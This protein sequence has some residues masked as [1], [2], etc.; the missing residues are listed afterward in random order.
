[1]SPSSCG[2]S[3]RAALAVFNVPASP[4]DAHVA[5]GSLKTLAPMFLVRVYRR[6]RRA[7]DDRRRFPNMEVNGVPPSEL[8]PLLTRSGA[9]VVC[10]R[11]DQT[12]G[13]AGPGFLYCITAKAKG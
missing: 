9:T 7:L 3:T 10:V 11:P 1:M 8:V 5:G 6:A 12:H 13:D 4:L 2:F